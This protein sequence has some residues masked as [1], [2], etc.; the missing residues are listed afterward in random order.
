MAGGTGGHI[1]PGLAVADTLMGKGVSVRWLGARGGMECQKVPQ[2]GIPLD[3]V[4]ISGLRG[5]FWRVRGRARW[6]RRQ[7]ARR[8]AAGA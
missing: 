8:A 4:D 6:P 2:A 7:A 1:F 5:Q 3:V